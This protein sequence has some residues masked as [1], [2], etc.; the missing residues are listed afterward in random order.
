MSE[1]VERVDASHP[2]FEL[3]APDLAVETGNLREEMRAYNNF[4]TTYSYLGDMGL[5]IDYYEKK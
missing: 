4:G 3:V 5:S 1:S 2:L